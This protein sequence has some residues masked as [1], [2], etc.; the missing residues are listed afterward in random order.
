MGIILEPQKVIPFYQREYVWADVLRD[1][2]VENILE[3]F[4][5]GAS[6]YSDRWF[7]KIATMAKRR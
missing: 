1:N 3:A 5:A 7:F 2:F 4:E 6:Y